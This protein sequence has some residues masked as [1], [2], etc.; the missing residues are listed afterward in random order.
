MIT[1]GLGRVRLGKY[2]VASLLLLTHASH[3]KLRSLYLGPRTRRPTMNPCN[4]MEKIASTIAVR[5]KVF[6]L[7][8]ALALP[9]R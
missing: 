4:K 6:P 3:G 5:W 9:R 8:P 2:R 1:L 7:T